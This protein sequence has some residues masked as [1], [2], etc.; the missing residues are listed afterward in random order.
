MDKLF[1]TENAYEIAKANR[2]VLVGVNFTSDGFDSSD[3]K[4]LDELEGLLETA[5][6]ECLGKILQNRQVPDPATFIGSGKVEEIREFAKAN[7]GGMVVFDNELSPTQIRNLEGDI[8]VRVL[9]RSML[10]LDIFAM[11]ATTKEAKLQVELAQIK[12][13]LPRLTS[14]YEALS[15]LGGGIGTRGPGETKLETDRRN[16]KDKIRI[17]ETELKDVIKNREVLRKQRMKNPLPLIAIIG[18]TNVGKSTLFNRLTNAGVLEEDKL[19]A[20]LETVVRKVKISDT[21]DA[22]MSDTVGF[23][24]KLPHHLVEAFKSTLEEMVYAD[25]ILLVIDPNI[26]GFERDEEVSYKIMREVGVKDTPIITV[27]NKCDAYHGEYALKRDMSV[28]ISSRT[29]ENMQELL[30]MIESELAKLKKELTV[31]IPYADGGVVAL[32]HKRGDV[33]AEEYVEDGT[34]ITL[35]ADAQLYG[36]IEKYI[37]D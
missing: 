24:N 19:F 10:I 33:L 15:K 29:G 26:E 20:T 23:I 2:A 21:C 13:I 18:Y 32:I 37:I 31:L 16:I 1:S 9:D 34:R 22:L 27:F 14:S 7:D 30:A 25:L 3:E 36:N 4:S 11:R 8:G 17:L 12:Y 35:R 6:G 28:M 5:G